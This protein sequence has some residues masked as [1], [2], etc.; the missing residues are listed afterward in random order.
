MAYRKWDSSLGKKVVEDWCDL[1]LD[2]I[3][4]LKY[5]PFI[6]PDR[7]NASSSSYWTFSGI[8]SLL[9]W[10]YTDYGDNEPHCPPHLG[11]YKLLSLFLFKDYLACSVECS[12]SSVGSCFW[13]QCRRLQKRW[14]LPALSTKYIIL[15]FQKP[16]ANMKAAFD[17]KT[18]RGWS[19]S[20][21]VPW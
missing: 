19:N 5:F 13:E 7:N 10:S 15:E 4:T 6:K 11:N 3:S 18:M 1:K 9:S 14:T 16:R 8:S 21:E 17:R 2:L 12:I 20:W